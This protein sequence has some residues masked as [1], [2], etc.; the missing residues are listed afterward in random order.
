MRATVIFFLGSSVETD[1]A[2]LLVRCTLGRFSYAPRVSSMVHKCVSTFLGLSGATVPFV[3]HIATPPGAFGARWRR[4]GCNSMSGY[5]VGALQGVSARHLSS[6]VLIFMFFIR[7]S[8]N[9]VR[10]KKKKKKKLS[11]ISEKPKRI[12]KHETKIPPYLILFFSGLSGGRFR[13][14]GQLR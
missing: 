2:R 6:H 1:T 14:Y 10:P 9:H 11:A 3:P 7:R 12:E 5:E 4:T 8:F 13:C